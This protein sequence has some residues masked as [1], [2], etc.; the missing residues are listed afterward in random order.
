MFKLLSLHTLSSGLGTV[1]GF[2]FITTRFDISFYAMLFVRI[3]NRIHS[4]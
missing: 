4:W 2:R 3:T 1:R